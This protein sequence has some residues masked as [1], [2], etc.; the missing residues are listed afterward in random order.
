MAGPLNGIGGQVP[1]ATTFQPGQT[2]AQVRPKQDER[3]PLPN[4]IQ[5]REAQA[6][7][8]QETRPRDS[9]DLQGLLREA[10]ASGETGRGSVIDITV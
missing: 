6:A 10:Q 3:T 8:S 7:Q 5:P 4:Q 1:F 2:G 9:R